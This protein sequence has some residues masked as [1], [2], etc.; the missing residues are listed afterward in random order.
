MEIKG[1]DTIG[2]E[3][4]V[5]RIAFA[6][7][8]PLGV[9]TSERCGLKIDARKDMTCAVSEENAVWQLPS[10]LRILLDARLQLVHAVMIARPEENESLLRPAF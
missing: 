3:D 5:A 1:K 4:V 2:Y 6:W 8:D 9:K 10:A 7:D